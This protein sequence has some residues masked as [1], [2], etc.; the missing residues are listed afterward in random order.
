MSDQAF[1]LL[2]LVLWALVVAE[3]IT[4]RIVERRRRRELARELRERAVADDF[5][6]GELLTIL[7]RYMDGGA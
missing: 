1:S 2:L 4:W 5:T 7:R 3:R 6:S